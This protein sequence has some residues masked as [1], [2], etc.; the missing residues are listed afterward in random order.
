M[1][2][3]KLRTLFFIAV[4]LFTIQGISSASP[5]NDSTMLVSRP[6]V[7][8]NNIAFVYGEDLWVADINGSQ[9]WRLTDG[10]GIETNPAFHRTAA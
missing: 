1:K 7:N 3:V 9:V 2:R 6:A 4:M 10:G 8:D 5:G